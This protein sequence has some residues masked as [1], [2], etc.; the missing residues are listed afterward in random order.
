M[1]KLGLRAFANNIITN[2]FIIIQLTAV[3]LI[4][5]TAISSANSRYELYRPF[6][7]LFSKKGEVTFAIPDRYVTESDYLSEINKLNKLENAVFSYKVNLGVAH[8]KSGMTINLSNIYTRTYAYDKEIIDMYEP[9]LD[10]GKWF[11]GNSGEYISCV[12]SE[13]EVGDVMELSFQ[14]PDGSYKTVMGKVCGVISDR[15]R[16]MMYS[17]FDVLTTDCNAIFSTYYKALDNII[18]FNAEELRKINVNL[19]PAGYG[20]VEYS[21]DITDEDF[22]KNGLT[23]SGIG[24][25]ITFERLN[26]NSIDNIN[27]QM[28]M[29]IPVLVCVLILVIMCIFSST[30][31]ESKKQLRNYAI[32]Y[33]NGARWNRVFMIGLVEMAV[34]AALSV[35][36]SSTLY[37]LLALLNISE[38]FVLGIDVV[39]V[40]AC[41][42]IIL[43]T[44]ICSVIMPVLI[45]RKSSPKKLLY[46]SI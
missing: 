16:I 6:E 17:D 19:I 1:I 35:L 24:G 22:E 5:T 18:I 42:A 2:I 8:T 12:V 41:A 27:A 7:P 20:Y 25:H 21:E 29:L 33:I 32:Y 15:S 23:L 26:E 36:I 9:K 38:N 44:L 46:S 13:G 40:L 28:T 4:A 45:I 37:F 3:L 43:L 34:N 10:S 30:S 39:S 14:T 11:D 31:I